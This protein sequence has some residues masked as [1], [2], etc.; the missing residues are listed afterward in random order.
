M[1]K[2]LTSKS[3]QL[4]ALFVLIFID[5]LNY[6]LVIPVFERLFSTQYHFLPA[7]TTQGTRDL[8][9]GIAVLLSPLAF[10]IFAP[11]V[12]HL[13]DKFGRKKV[14]L[15]CL[16]SSFIGY[17]LPVVGIASS[18]LWLIFAGR[19]L[20]GAS[21]GS[22]PI[23]Q[24]A[25]ADITQ[26]KQKAFYLA[27][28]AF[29]MTL[30]MTVGPAAGSYLSDATLV[31]WFTAA[32][33]YW[34]GVILS[35]LNILLVILFLRETHAPPKTSPRL[36]PSLLEVLN[37]PLLI[38]LLVV[39]FLLEL[40]WSQYYQVLFLFMPKVFNY[41]TNHVAI[42]T[43]YIGLWMSLGL[44][45]FYRLV[46]RYISIDKFLRLSLVIAGIGLL[47]LSLIHT[48]HAQWIF[49]VFAAVFIGTAYVNLLALLSNATD[50]EH[51][52]WVLGITSTLLGASWAITGYTSA[53][54][55]NI[56][57][58]LPFYISTICIIIAMLVA[59]YPQK[60]K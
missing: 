37:K 17:L 39:F 19:F 26:G 43:S 50:P 27:I 57:S 7:A 34:I 32:T 18:Q 6:F 9:F 29:A 25:V 1:N 4:W 55:V 51:Q 52:G 42:F 28:I 44:T 16:S 12:G 59:F 56:S 48:A 36:G 14:L 54:L 2:T 20:A 46:I 5:S 10:V 60:K 41:S 40:C 53:V 21:T 24:A 8:L 30:A 3:G 58:R 35:F 47:G 11:I 38:K 49:V 22:Q 31:S 13:S 33:P 23:A 45:V 15:G